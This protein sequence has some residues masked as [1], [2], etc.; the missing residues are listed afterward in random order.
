MRWQ[1]EHHIR[2]DERLVGFMAE[3]QLLVR[4]TPHVLIVKLPVKVGIHS[5]RIFIL[6]RPD[7]REIGTRGLA[8]GLAFL[9]KSF[10][11]EKFRGG[12]GARPFGD[13]EVVFKVHGGEVGD[14]VAEGFDGGTDFGCKRD[15]GEDGEGAGLETDWLGRYVSYVGWRAV[16]VDIIPIVPLP[17]TLKRPKRSKGAEQVVMFGV[18]FRMTITSPGFEGISLDVILRIG[19]LVAK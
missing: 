5:Q 3:H 19:M 14:I 6:H 16:R 18:T 8:A 17:P 13:E 11:A 7:V 2:F 4:M 12:E 9:G 1:V 10:D 15:G